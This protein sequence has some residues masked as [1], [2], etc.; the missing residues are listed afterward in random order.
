[1]KPDETV[2]RQQ[3]KPRII[4]RR[5]VEEY[6]DDAKWNVYEYPPAEE[7]KSLE[8]ALVDTHI[9]WVLDHYEVGDDAQRDYAKLL[10]MDEEELTD[11]SRS[12]EQANPSSPT[13]VSH[14]HWRYRA[15]VLLSARDFI[16][17]E[18]GDVEESVRYAVEEILDG[19]L[20]LKY[21]AS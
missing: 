19:E 17:E 2:N 14:N 4:D 11:L 5:K 7:L 13:E 15:V 9:R 6:E 12:A 8:V 20:R 3:S 18:S 16:S 1:M 10:K 21:L